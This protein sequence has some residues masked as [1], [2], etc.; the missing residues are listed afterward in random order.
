MEAITSGAAPELKAA[1]DSA[2][3]AKTGAS[4]KKRIEGVV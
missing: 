1:I 2:L 3:E 4:L